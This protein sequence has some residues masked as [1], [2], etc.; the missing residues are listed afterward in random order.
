MKIKSLWKKTRKEKKREEA[1]FVYED[2]S[3]VERLN[4]HAFSEE[5]I[6]LG[7]EANAVGEVSEGFLDVNDPPPSFSHQIETHVPLT[8]SFSPHVRHYT[9]CS[10]FDG[11]ITTFISLFF[12]SFVDPPQAVSPY[13]VA[14]SWRVRRWMWGLLWMVGRL[15]ACPWS[16]VYKSGRKRC[17]CGCG[18]RFWGITRP[19]NPR[20]HNA[21][22]LLHL[23][24]LR[25]NPFVLLKQKQTQLICSKS[26]RKFR[27]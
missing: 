21:I 2:H 1:Y 7:C 27:R 4:P 9:P 17:C 26:T 11:S 3:T 23:R 13:P 10:N 24:Y 22:F 18:F 12:I 14:W 8:A 15:F 20:R 16:R 6:L 5:P 25:N 19:R